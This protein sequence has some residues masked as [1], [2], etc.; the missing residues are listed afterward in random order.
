MVKRTVEEKTRRANMI[1]RRSIAW[2][3]EVTAIQTILMP[4]AVIML[5]DEGSNILQTGMIPA[6]WNLVLWGAYCLV[7]DLLGT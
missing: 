6:K 4:V 5:A 2:L 3:I 1:N 7:R